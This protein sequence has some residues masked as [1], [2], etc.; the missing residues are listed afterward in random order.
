[1]E[2]NCFGLLLKDIIFDRSLLHALWIDS[3]V[4]WSSNLATSWYHCVADKS[5]IPKV[6][7]IKH[8]KNIGSLTKN[9]EKTVLTGL[10]SPRLNFFKKRLGG[11][12]ISE[13]RRY[14]VPFFK[15][16]MS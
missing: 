3:G 7:F 14:A 13:N 9:S 10:S 1:M 2:L 12:D 15:Q 8:L 4:F 6:P 11:G 5:R 16:L